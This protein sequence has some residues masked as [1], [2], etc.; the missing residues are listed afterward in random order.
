VL[1][2]IYVLFIATKQYTSEVSLLPPAGKFS[3]GLLGSLGDLGQM[4]GLSLGSQSSQSPEMY[5][6]I[7][8]SRRVLEEALYRSYTAELEG[9]IQRGNLIFWL[10]IEGK[11]EREII[12]KALK[13]M[14]E[15]VVNINIDIDNSILYMAITTPNADVSS[16]V[17]NYMSRQLND[18]VVNDVQK[19]HR[20]QLAYLT[21][22]LEEAKDSLRISENDLEKFLEMNFDTSIPEYQ[23]QQ[24]RLQR[25]VTINTEIYIEF[26]KQY[27]IFVLDNLIN[28]ADVKI[29]DEA[30]PSYKKSRPKRA[31][32]TI[33]LTVIGLFLLFVGNA[34]ALA[35]QNTFKQ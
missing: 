10:D 2:L 3:G 21:Q 24:L 31:L 26:R 28:L 1:V 11:N 27:E 18:I 6:G 35:Y 15:E 8:K 23:F 16:Q 9:E 33:S 29:L 17:A 5:M 13:A 22:K 32:L 30:I 34:L 12:E 25:A 19:E 20:Q 7:L 14:R 4:A